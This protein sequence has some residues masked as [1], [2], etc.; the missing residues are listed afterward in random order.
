M[1]F[2]G[3]R[4]STLRSY[5]VQCFQEL[6]PLH[7]DRRP[8]TTESFRRR[9]SPASDRR[10]RPSPDHGLPRPPFDPDPRWPAA[11]DGLPSNL[12]YR[13]AGGLVG[14]Q[15]CGIDYQGASNG[16]TLLLAAGQFV[17][18]VLARFSMSTQLS[19]QRPG[20]SLPHAARRQCGEVAPRFQGPTVLV[21]DSSSEIQSLV[22]GAG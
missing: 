10:Q 21:T 20:R 6:W 11:G 2:R 12:C 15:Y 1:S 3:S 13:D 8:Q 19:A 7:R 4:S 5:V 16:H 9:A 22:G 18:Q 17:R 14:Q